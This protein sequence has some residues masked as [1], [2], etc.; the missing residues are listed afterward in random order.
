MKFDAIRNRYTISKLLRVFNPA[1]QPPSRRRA[2]PV[3]LLKPLM[4][5]QYSDVGPSGTNQPQVEI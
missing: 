5:A 4:M 3:G 2:S 1:L